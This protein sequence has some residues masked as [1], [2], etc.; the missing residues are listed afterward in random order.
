MPEQLSQERWDSE[1]F[2][3]SM[4]ACAAL[5][6]AMGF[7]GIPGKHGCLCSFLKSDGIQRDSR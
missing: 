7:R 6:K 1:G 2:Q 5:S 3:L 4:G